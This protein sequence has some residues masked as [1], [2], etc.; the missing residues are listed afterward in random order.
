LIAVDSRGRITMAFNT[1]G[2]FRG[3]ADASGR[4]EVGVRESRVLAA[5]VATPASLTAVTG[6]SPSARAGSE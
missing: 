6:A 1:E 4:L 5:G 2:M 3:A